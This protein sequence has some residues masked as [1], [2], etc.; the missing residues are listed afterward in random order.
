SSLP[1]PDPT[2]IA[3]SPDMEYV[4][5]TNFSDDSMSVIGA[6]PTS[7]NFHKEL[8]RVKTGVGPKS[9]AVQPENEDIF[10][11]DFLGNTVSI[12][13]SSSLTIRKQLTSL[14]NG[15]FDVETTE[16]QQQPGS[17][18]PF[19]WQCG[20]YF[21]YISN[22]SGNSVVVFESGPDGPQGIGIDNI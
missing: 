13:N 7:A 6:D 20:I 4:F 16:R 17:P 22:F 2:G 15:P 9:I 3:I 8:A 1:L 10:V 5:V 14:I 19:G 21:G 11:C 18:H 12:I